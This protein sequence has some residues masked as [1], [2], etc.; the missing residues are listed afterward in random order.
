M[1][2]GAQTAD[3]LETTS[4]SG[5]GFGWALATVGNDAPFK[6][7]TAGQNITI[8]SSATEL[9]ISTT[10]A[11]GEDNTTSNSGTGEGLAQTKVG[12]DLPFKSL[13]GETNRIVL[14]GNTNDVT[15]TIGTDIV[16]LSSTQSVSNKT[17]LGPNGTELLPTYAFVNS[18]STG[19]R[20][21]STTPAL[22]FSLA[23]QDILKLTAS[24]DNFLNIATGDIDA[25]EF[26]QIKPLGLDT[27]IDLILNSKGGGGVNINAGSGDGEVNIGENDTILVSNLGAIAVGTQTALGAQN[28]TGL[29]MSLGAKTGSFTRTRMLFRSPTN[30]KD[31]TIGVNQDSVD[32]GSAFL[33]YT[34]GT[35][36][37]LKNSAGTAVSISSLNSTFGG[38]VSAA[39]EYQQAGSTILVGDSTLFN[40]FIGFNAGSANTT[41]TGNTAVGDGALTTNLTGDDNTA[42][43]GDALS[44]NV[45]DGNSA[46]GFSSLKANTTGNGNPAFVPFVSI[47]EIDVVSAPSDTMDETP[48]ISELPSVT[49]PNVKDTCVSVVFVYGNV[50]LPSTI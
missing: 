40:T 48:L 47:V 36:M 42:M 22:A 24:G 16:D 15:F 4:N 26:I 37:R 19:M 32:S 29:V 3:V 7:V 38:S 34:D 45:D 50:S 49:L 44:V 43:G 41:G 12:V 9:E 6:S 13:L 20:Y 28:T 17:L 31:F 2:L 11:A 23:G 1:D 8:T 35:E 18:A 14:T 21:D 25:E 5:T 33:E 10:D 39:T 27:N 30:S 46:F